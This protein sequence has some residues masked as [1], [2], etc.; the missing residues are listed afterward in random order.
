MLMS[1][2][3][4]SFVMHRAFLYPLSQ[5]SRLKPALGGKKAS[6]SA[7]SEGETYESPVGKVCCSGSSS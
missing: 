6:L 1:I 4:Y 7:T 3:L 2:A 5:V